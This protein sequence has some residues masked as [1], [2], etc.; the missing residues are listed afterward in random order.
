MVFVVRLDG[1]DHEIEFVGAVDFP[2][3]AVILARREELGFG[4]VVQAINPAGRVIDHEEH[5]TGAVFRP[6]EQEQMVGA[7]VEH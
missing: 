1:L 7:E 5:K 6:R 3:H 2:E 4:E